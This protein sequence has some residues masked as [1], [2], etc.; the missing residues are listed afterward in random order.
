MLAR[1]NPPQPASRV[2]G[3]VRHPARA[4]LT[5]MLAGLAAP[6]AAQA[7]QPGAWDVTSTVIDLSVP[8]VPGFLQRM[9]RGKSK[10]EHKRLTAGQDVGALLA[11]DPNARC[12]VDSQ[13]VEAGRYAQS[14]T[15]PQKKG[16]PLRIVRTGTYDARGFAGQATVTGV[17]P[18][19]PL[20]IALAQHAAR[21]GS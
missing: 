4:L 2:I 12:R 5:M 7:V 15:C 14:L 10:A 19:G 13:T 3:T 20:S 1:R 17:T 18:K 21:T 16:D 9:V 6:A 8:G 11:P